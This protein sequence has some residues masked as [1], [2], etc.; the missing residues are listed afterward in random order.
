[1][2]TR[3]R[4]EVEQKTK[5][6]GERTL[7]FDLM[8][9]TRG[10]KHVMGGRG[11]SQVARMTCLNTFSNSPNRSLPQYVETTSGRAF[12]TPAHLDLQPFILPHFVSTLPWLITLKHPAISVVETRE[13][14]MKSPPTS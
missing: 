2:S 6:L 11:M 5:K 14:N 1:M 12:L 3:R 10:T 7:C 9:T 8:T 13:M 4:W